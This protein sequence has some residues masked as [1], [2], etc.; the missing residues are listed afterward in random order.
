M[1]LFNL[2]GCIDIATQTEDHL[3]T[4]VGASCRLLHSRPVKLQSTISSPS[5]QGFASQSSDATYCLPDCD[6]MEYEEE[7]FVLNKFYIQFALI[8][9]MF[10]IW[11][12]CAPK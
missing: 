4:D 5:T 3:H 7:R 2:F 12:V 6:E 11:I 9:M 8:V 1:R 10:L